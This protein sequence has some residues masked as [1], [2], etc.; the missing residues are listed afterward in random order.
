MEKEKGCDERRSYPYSEFVLLTSSYYRLTKTFGFL[1]K[2]K[3][4]ISHEFG[5]HV[6]PS[7]FPTSF[8]GYPLGLSAVKRRAR[9]TIEGLQKMYLLQ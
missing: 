3:P 7:H 6:R 1:L 2:K 8:I 5:V 4:K 9:H